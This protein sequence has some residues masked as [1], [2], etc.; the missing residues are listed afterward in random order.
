MNEQAFNEK[1]IKYLSGE[2]S[3]EERSDFEQFAH[4]DPMR[5]KDLRAMTH[6]WK[7]AAAYDEEVVMSSLNEQ[8]DKFSTTAFTAEKTQTK[9][10]KWMK[11][12]VRIA[13]VLFVVMGTF[14]AWNLLNQPA[15]SRGDLTTIMAETQTRE[16]TLPDG[17]VVWLNAQSSISYDEIFSDRIVTLS[18]EAYFEVEHLQNDQLF[19]VVAGD[20]RTTVLGTIFNVRAFPNEDV[21]SVYVR[22]GKVS[23]MEVRNQKEVTLTAGLAVRY[24]TRNGILDR[25]TSGTSNAMAWKTGVLEYT[26]EAL[27]RILTDLENLYGAKF[28]VEDHLMNCPYSTTIENDPLHVIIEELKF[29]LEVDV[30]K[31]QDATYSISGKGCHLE[32]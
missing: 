7:E 13:A 21:V 11:P 25:V 1:T 32:Q 3:T 29:A 6:L 10:I 27:A 23:V 4:G 2:M 30:V 8:W 31:G 16:V 9:I 15:A 24:N 18:G 17:S 22:E 28:E 14:Y 19:Q 26:D 5:E 20:A 12:I